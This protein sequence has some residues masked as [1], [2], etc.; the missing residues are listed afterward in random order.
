MN[1]PPTSSRD[2]RQGK[3]V[4]GAG[5]LCLVVVLA[6][7]ITLRNPAIA[8]LGGLTIRLGLRVNPVKRGSRLSSIS[9]Q[10]AVV[11][12][13]FALGFDR[14]MTVSADYG[15][16]VGAYVLMTLGLG[17]ILPVG[18]G[19]LPGLPPDPRVRGLPP[20]QPSP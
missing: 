11:L 14:M 19:N 4:R 17:W 5:W 18:P 20:P 9:L 1:D 7:G 13:G 12:L 15:A 8:L 2:T 3:G 16:V 10:T 6:A